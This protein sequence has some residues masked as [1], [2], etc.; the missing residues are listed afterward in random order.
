MKNVIKR[1]PCKYVCK[2][3]SVNIFCKR[4]VT[5]SLLVLACLTMQAQ[6]MKDV[7]VLAKPSGIYMM[8]CPEG[9]IDKKTK[10][11]TIVWP[12]TENNS[13]H[14]NMGFVSNVPTI[15]NFASIFPEINISESSS[16]SPVVWQLT[17]ENDETVL[18]CY[19]QMPADV[20]TNMWLVSDECVI[21][22]KE[23]GAIYQSRRTNPDCYGKVFNVKAK[24][25]AVLDF[26]V[27]FPKLPETT[28]EIS[29]YG[30]PNWFMR[31]TDV[32]L[33]EARQK[34]FGTT[35]GYDEVPQFHKAHLV[36][37]EKDYN[38]D[39]HQSWAVYDDAHLIKPVKEGT[40]AIWLT[41][42]ATYLAVATE[43]NWM[44]EYFG[45][46]GD[47]MLI[48][49][50][51]HQYKCKDVLGYPNDKLFWLDGCSGDYF[52]IVQVFEPVPID[53]ETITYIVPE[54]EPF[55]MWGANWSGEVHAGLNIQDLRDNQKLFEYHKRVV[56]K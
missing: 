23:T 21:L 38:K 15:D 11:K 29:I 14:E 50:S 2:W 25:G 40:M 26:Q 13:W 37:E 43:M 49:S 52:A 1:E 5:L 22:D 39:N 30:V 33:Y 24:E 32:T 56:V 41:P 42:D 28:K 18:H 16:Y 10:K 27:F 9:T 8:A 7:K 31:G 6:Q 12:D 19:F 45:R 35:L 47:N 36:S 4:I 54:G 17:E 3:P 51:G 46:G 53:V 55:S 20:V 48:D 44:R 34:F